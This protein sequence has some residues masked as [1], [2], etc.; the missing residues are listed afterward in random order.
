MLPAFRRAKVK[1]RPWS[2]SHDGADGDQRRGDLV[3]AVDE[4]RSGIKPSVAL[5]LSRFEPDMLVLALRLAPDLLLFEPSTR[6]LPNVEDAA[7][8]VLDEKDGL[9]KRYALAQEIDL[10]ATK[11]PTDAALQKSARLSPL[12]GQ[13]SAS[14]QLTALA[15]VLPEAR[16]HLRGLAEEAQALAARRTADALSRVAR[17]ERPAVSLRAAPRRP[18]QPEPNLKECQPPASWDQFEGFLAMSMGPPGRQ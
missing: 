5:E 1:D 6:G 18:P 17:H 14:D 8:T 2:R 16:K 12:P 11:I 9:A 13:V 3:P 10:R 7:R 4:S 15:A